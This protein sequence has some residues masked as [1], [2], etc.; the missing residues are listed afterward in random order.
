MEARGVNGTNDIAR[1]KFSQS[2]LMSSMQVMDGTTTSTRLFTKGAEQTSLHRTTTFCTQDW[3]HHPLPAH[4]LD[5]LLSSTTTATRCA[6]ERWP[7][8]FDS[9]TWVS[10][11]VYYDIQPSQNMAKQCGLGPSFLRSV[12]DQPQPKKKS[13]LRAIKRTSLTLLNN[14]EFDRSSQL[15]HPVNRAPP[16]KRRANRLSGFSWNI[17]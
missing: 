2:S 17:G 1:C 7:E 12:S 6:H 4:L 15:A 3:L 13:C 11:A 5:D 14:L 9:A 16:S 10:G 8:G